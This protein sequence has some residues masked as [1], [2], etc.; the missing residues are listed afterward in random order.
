MRTVRGGFIFPFLAWN[1]LY[2]YSSARVMVAPTPIR[3]EEE[4]EAS[5]QRGLSKN[6]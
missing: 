2:D 1:L 3:K 5:A 4:E 6:P